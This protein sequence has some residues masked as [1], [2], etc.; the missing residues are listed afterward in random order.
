LALM[1]HGAGRASRNMNWGYPLADEFGVVLVSPDSRESTW[2]AIQGDQGPDVEFIDR[3]LKSVFGR[4]RIDPKK[5]ACVGFSD[6]ASYALSLGFAN[7]DLF[8]YVMAFSPGFI[9][10]NPRVGKPRVFISHGTADRVLPI[11]VT[12]R[13]ITPG[14]KNEGYDLTYR[15]FDGPH[16]VMPDIAHDAFEWFLK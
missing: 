9:P 15:E 14:L 8:G 3:A 13:V 4:I 11:D 12:S 16:R 1:L 6:G 10:R 5:L 7:G 2:D